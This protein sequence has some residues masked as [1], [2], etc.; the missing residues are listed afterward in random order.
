MPLP[1]MHIIYA[2]GGHSM[3]TTVDLDKRLVEELM[4]A[5]RAKTKTEAIHLA[6]TDLIRRQKIE[7]LKALSGTTPLTYVRPALRDAEPGS[8]KRR[9]T[10]P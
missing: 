7:R 3:R 5:T 10:R 8:P 2:Y 6:M 9:R 4:K 1:F